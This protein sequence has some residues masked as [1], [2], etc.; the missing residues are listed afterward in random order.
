M[1]IKKSVPIRAI[2]A[3]CGTVPD[4]AYTIG[5][6]KMAV[7]IDGSPHDYPTRQKRDSEQD[8]ALMLAGWLVLR[9]HHSDNWDELIRQYPSVFG[10]KE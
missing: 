6:N 3:D 1:V 5:A 7:F 8:A 4:F 9:F 10:G 2:I